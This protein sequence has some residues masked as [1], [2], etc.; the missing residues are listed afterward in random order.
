LNL[1][2]AA[3][4]YRPLGAIAISRSVSVPAFR[5]FFFQVILFSFA[6]ALPTVLSAQAKPPSEYELKAAFLFNFAK[7][8]EWPP[9]A[10]PDP[11]SPIV[12]CTFDDDAFRA[13]LA[14]VVR[15]KVINGRE[16]VVRRMTK[17]EALS[18]CQV[19]F[20]GAA[21]GKRLPELLDALKGATTLLVSD[22][23]GSAERGGGIEFF[24]E[25]SK[26]R[27]SINLDAVQRAHLAISSKLLS[28]AKIVHDQIHGERS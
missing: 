2:N 14:E 18:S 4:N 15:A 27:F 9:A 24:V 10:Y 17:A 21:E 8:I 11:R 13:I 19:V 1:R 7:F 25:D 5:L 23:P 12:L 6:Y 26:M 3:P 20:V 28:L 16:L 22:I